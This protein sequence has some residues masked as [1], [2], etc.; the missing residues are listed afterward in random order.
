MIIA[1]E[2]KYFMR[3]K[4]PETDSAQPVDAA[5]IHPARWKRRYYLGRAGMV[6][7]W[8]CAAGEVPGVEDGNERRVG[9]MMQGFGDLK[10]KRL[11]SDLPSLAIARRGRGLW[12]RCGFA[13]ICGWGW[14]WS[15]WRRCC[16]R[17]P[18]RNA[19]TLGRGWCIACVPL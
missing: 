5:M 9:R 16:G 8:D 3:L 4:E 11:R 6:G 12:T 1:I 19:R 15:G 13:G 2:T 17:S 14:G 7:S 10:L 18:R